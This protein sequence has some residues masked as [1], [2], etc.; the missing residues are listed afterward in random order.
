MDAGPGLI[1]HLI[2]LGPWGPEEHLGVLRCTEHR[3]GG[4]WTLGLVPD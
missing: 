1:A 3:V 4:V 2:F